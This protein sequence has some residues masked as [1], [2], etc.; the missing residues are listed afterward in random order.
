MDLGKTIKAYR[1]SKKTT[2]KELASQINVTAS[3]LS[4]IENNKKLPSVDT[5]NKLAE[6]FNI[7]LYILF[8]D[9]SDFEIKTTENNFSNQDSFMLQA[10]ALFLS[11]D[12]SKED[13]ESIFKDITDL[14]WKAK[15]MIK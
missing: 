10:R 7:P 6:A 12:L 11:D 15:G 1:N 4:D 8:K 14:Y 5:L 2:L 13:K 3:F 9:F